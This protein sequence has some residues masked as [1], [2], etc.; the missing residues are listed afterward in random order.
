MRYCPLQAW[1]L[2]GNVPLKSIFYAI[3]LVFDLT[4]LLNILV[5]LKQNLQGV[6][7][8]HGKIK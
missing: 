2:R 1:L 7:T 6:L 8:L 4:S 3:V 5:V